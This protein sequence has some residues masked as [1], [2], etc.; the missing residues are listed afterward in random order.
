MGAKLNRQTQGAHPI[1]KMRYSPYP[2][3]FWVRKALGAYSALEA[4]LGTVVEQASRP[5]PWLA[6][7]GIVSPPKFE[8]SV[9]SGVAKSSGIWRLWAVCGSSVACRYE[10]ATESLSVSPR[11]GLTE[12]KDLK[13]KTN[14]PCRVLQTHIVGTIQ[15]ARR[16]Y[17]M[18]IQCHRIGAVAWSVRAVSS[19]NLY[20]KGRPNSPPAPLSRTVR[21]Y[22]VLHNLN[23]SV[24]S[25]WVKIPGAN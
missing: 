23:F 5:R 16:M 1:S 3:Y 6:C 15:R 11:E 22:V 20:Q 25:S 2:V 19:G 14:Q 7:S 21:I 9:I 17:C 10:V 4:N 13:P 8:R 12:C 24:M 18:Y